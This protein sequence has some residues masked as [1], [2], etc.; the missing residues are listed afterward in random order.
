MRKCLN[1]RV[2]AWIRFM[3]TFTTS[4]SSLIGFRNLRKIKYRLIYILLSIQ[5][6]LDCSNIIYQS[7]FE[8]LY[9]TNLVSNIIQRHF[10]WNKFMNILGI[11][12]NSLSGESSCWN[13][14]MI[15]NDFNHPTSTTTTSW[16]SVYIIGTKRHS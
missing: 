9:R 7:L 11:C 8:T 5:F 2:F 13:K 16:H 3:F 14:R 4:Y 12:W 10:D 1:W 6:L 15:R